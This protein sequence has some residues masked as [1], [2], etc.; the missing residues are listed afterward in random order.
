LTPHPGAEIYIGGS[1]SN[2]LADSFLFR[3]EIFWTNF[4]NHA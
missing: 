4:T 1:F 3:K 2:I